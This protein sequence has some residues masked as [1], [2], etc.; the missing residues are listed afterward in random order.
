M[1]RADVKIF[2]EKDQ[3]KEQAVY[4]GWS[5]QLIELASHNY[6]SWSL[7]SLACIRSSM[8]HNQRSQMIT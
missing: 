3:R 6:G 4:L 5:W 2:F 1:T 7:A 8:E